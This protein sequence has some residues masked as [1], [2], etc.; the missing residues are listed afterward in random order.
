MN[1]VYTLNET[2]TETDTLISTGGL[3]S[4]MSTGTFDNSDLTIE[5]SQNGL[6]FITLDDFSIVKDD[7]KTTE[8][9]I[10]GS[11]FKVKVN[12]PTTSTSIVVGI[13]AE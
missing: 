1:E 4:I 7:V 10:R 3:V 12:S 9:L 2:T 11:S 8:N 5:Y 6:D 13:A